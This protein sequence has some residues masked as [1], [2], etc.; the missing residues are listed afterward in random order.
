MRS[1]NMMFLGKRPALNGYRKTLG[2]KEQNIEI[3]FELGRKRESRT[4]HELLGWD[5]GSGKE[6]LV[7]QTRVNE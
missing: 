6:L 5:G 1:K 3:E 4:K 2:L 7:V